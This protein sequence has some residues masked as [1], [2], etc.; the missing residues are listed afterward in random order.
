MVGR[1][2]AR[3]CASSIPR[4]P[5]ARAVN[6]D[7]SL[8]EGPPADTWRETFGQTIDTERRRATQ[9]VDDHRQRLRDLDARITAQLDDAAAALAREQEHAA[10]AT[11]NAHTKVATLEERQRLILR[12]AKARNRTG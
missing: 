7:E 10:Q 12:E 1:S 2:F 8:R 4:V 9:R 6:V 3:L 11:I 5:P